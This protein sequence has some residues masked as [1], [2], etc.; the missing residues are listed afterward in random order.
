MNADTVDG[1]L[2]RNTV[3]PDFQHNGRR[4]KRINLEIPQLCVGRLGSTGGC[5]I[6]VWKGEAPRKGDKRIPSV[7]RRLNCYAG[8]IDR[9]QWNNALLG[10]TERDPQ[11][12]RQDN[13]ESEATHIDPPLCIFMIFELLPR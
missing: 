6:R 13:R 7:G 9:L 4:C 11:S 1:E 2:L 12:A 10:R 3:S 5:V 8:M